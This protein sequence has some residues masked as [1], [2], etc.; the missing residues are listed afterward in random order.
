MLIPTA[1]RELRQTNAARL[2]HLRRRCSVTSNPC[3]AKSVSRQYT[4]I[5]TDT[6]RRAADRLPDMTN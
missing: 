2:S 5:D 4:Q 1:F 3:V 6:L